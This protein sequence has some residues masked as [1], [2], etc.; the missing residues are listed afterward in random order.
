MQFNSKTRLF[1]SASP[2]DRQLQTANFN[3]TLLRRIWLATFSV[4][5][6]VQIVFWPEGENLICV[7]L[8]WLACMASGLMIMQSRVTVLYPWSSFL[9]LFFCLE[10]DLPLLI[11]T[12]QGNPLIHNLRVPVDTFSHLLLCQL[13]LLIMHFV[14]RCF[15]F[16]QDIR[17]SLQNHI[18]RP[19]GFFTTLRT[20][21]VWLFGAVGLVS[22]FYICVFVR[23]KQGGQIA[24]T[25]PVLERLASGMIPLTFM[26]FLLLIPGQ[27]LAAFN[28]NRARHWRFPLIFIGYVAAILILSMAYNGRGFM[29]IGFALAGVVSGVMVLS[30]QVQ[31]VVKKVFWLSCFG[32]IFIS[33]VGSDFAIALRVARDDRVNKSSGE[34]IHE[35]LTILTTER[36]RL[37]P[38]RK[39]MAQ[40]HDDSEAWYVTSA[41]FSRLVN[42]H[43]QDR[44]LAIGES[45]SESS[46]AS[47]GEISRERFLCTLPNPILKFFG[48]P[49][50]KDGVC[51]HSLG[52]WLVYFDGETPEVISGFATGGFIGDGY[53]LFGWGYL[54]LFGVAAFVL[55]ILSDSCYLIVTGGS[56]KSRANCYS[57]FALVGLM[58][59]YE[60]VS[61]LTIESISGMFSFIMRQPL[62]WLVLFGGLLAVIR[63]VAWLITTD[64]TRMFRQTAQKQFNSEMDPL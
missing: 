7:S 54:I 42:T 58:N 39:N 63:T 44:A 6:V 21:E 8:A 5:A 29:F 52:D 25:G 10:H 61:S 34:L 48:F 41:V 62:Q 49:F 24:P 33:T 36:S 19:L 26:P 56:G 50:D 46:K 51:A 31:L 35:T 20:W 3:V 18:L 14:Y 59:G 27:T 38:L 53:A 16:S 28:N 60:L 55:F 1:G 32:M 22:A 13:V 12:F 40:G 4:A 64:K 43:F 15:G 57:L 47:L 45:L 30:G 9:V 17:Q 23:M 37:Q 2:W 11:L